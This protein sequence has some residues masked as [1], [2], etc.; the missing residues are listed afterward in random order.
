MQTL[1]VSSSP[2]WF[3]LPR[4]KS[5]KKRSRTGN[6]T[7][8][9]WVKTRN[10]ANYTIRDWLDRTFGSTATYNL[11]YLKSCCRG[12][13]AHKETDVSCNKVRAE[14][15]KIPYLLLFQ[16]SKTR[17]CPLFGRA[18]S[19]NAKSICCSTGQLCNCSYLKNKISNVR[20]RSC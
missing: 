13:S 12:Y 7:R 6:R 10:V 5:K 20:R 19:K 2:L 4:H 14:R 3:P 15:R 17:D 9:A 1:S 11:R 8:G 16:G 18:Y